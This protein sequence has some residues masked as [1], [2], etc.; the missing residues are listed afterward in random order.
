MTAFMY[1]RNGKLDNHYAHP[2]D[3]YIH[4]DMTAKKVLH[5]R[6]TMHSQVQQYLWQG[7]LSGSLYITSAVDSGATDCCFSY[8]YFAVSPTLPLLC[9][10]RLG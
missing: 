2:L 10:S 6:C 7:S 9:I 1:I 8:V 5:D 3:L 4:I